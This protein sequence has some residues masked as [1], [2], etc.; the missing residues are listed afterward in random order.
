VSK[1]QVARGLAAH[2]PCSML[3]DTTNLNMGITRRGPTRVCW[4]PACFCWG[5][6]CICRG[7]ACFGCG[8]ACCCGGPACLRWGHAWSGW[9]PECFSK[10]P[11]SSCWGAACFCML[12]LGPSLRWLRSCV[13]LLGQAGLS[14]PAAA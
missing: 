10:G 4:G 6:A 8:P 9:S 3:K 13:L 2:G 11:T 7:L 12:L 14:G 5:P 1:A